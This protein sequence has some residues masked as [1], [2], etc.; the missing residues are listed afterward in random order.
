MGKHRDLLIAIV[1]GLVL[2]GAVIFGFSQM[3]RRVAGLNLTGTI[4]N[5]I[6]TP[7][8]EE[9]VTF[10]KKKLSALKLDGEYELEVKVGDTLYIVPVHKEVYEKKKVGESFTFPRPP[11]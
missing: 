9:Q 1:I 3:G 10:G 2:L 11:K 5:K 6:F 4:T 7:M 8:G